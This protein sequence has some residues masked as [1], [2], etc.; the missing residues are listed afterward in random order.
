MLFLKRL[1]QIYSLKVLETIVVTFLNVQIS[2]VT[3]LQFISHKISQVTEDAKTIWIVFVMVES[4]FHL[5]TAESS[6]HVQSRRPSPTC[7]L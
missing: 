2:E 7:K 3:R 5:F 1:R 6:Y 4:T